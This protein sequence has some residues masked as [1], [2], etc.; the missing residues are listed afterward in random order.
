MRAIRLD[1][2]LGQLAGWALV[3]AVNAAMIAITLKLPRSGIGTRVLHH[4]YDAGQ[5]LALGA[6]SAVGVLFWQR[7]ASRTRFGSHRFAPSVAVFGVGV[8]FGVWMLRDDF[9]G[10]AGSLVGDR[11][12]F[13]V[14]ALAIAACAGLLSLCAR[15][16]SWLAR[17]YLRLLP[18]GIA[19]ALVAA[20]HK[21]V[22]HDYPGLHFFASAW[23]AVL[24]GTALVTSPA[25]ASFRSSGWVALGAVVSWW[26]LFL[27]PSN[28]VRLELFRSSGSVV[29]P[30]LAR[31]ESGLSRSSTAVVSPEAARWFKSRDG[32]PDIPPNGPPLFARNAIVLL[33]VI[34]A[35]RADLF[36][37][38][39]DQ[40][41]PNLARLRRQSV[42]FTNARTPAPGTTLAVTSV[43]TSRYHAQIRWADQR[44]R[45]YP[46]QDPSPRF[47][48]L[49][50]AHGVIT[51]NLQGLPGLAMSMGI[52]RG[53]DEEKIL[54]GRGG[55]YA[56][57][58]EMI[59]ALIQR[60]GRASTP[61]EA[62]RAFFAYQ[63]YDDAHAPYDLG[64]KKATPFESYLAEV[65]GVDREIG[66]LLD[67]LDS[68]SLADRTTLIVTADH[69]EAFGEHN[70]QFHATTLYDELLR[71]PLLVKIPSVAP[72][73][74]DVPVS[75][76]DLAPTLLDAFGLP[77][78]GRFMG[79]SLVPLLR[80]PRAPKLGRPIVAESDRGHRAMIFPDGMKV[81]VDDKLHTF[82]LYDL[83]RDPG[84]LQNLAD[85]AAD[86]G[87]QRRALLDTFFAAHRLRR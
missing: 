2:A 73:T 25:E 23:A 15:V 52:L 13:V 56:G 36:R 35:G 21:V 65:Q 8:L 50:R 33:L 72:R 76:V 44:G 80:D 1:P 84:E 53:F 28:A 14:V 24:A 31:I 75:L 37:P 43:L 20:N 70:K 17:G 85:S 10:F 16:G 11:W 63:H 71:V 39:H 66:R 51:L 22:S 5:L 12:S 58:P 45:E 55:H 41:L 79:Q 47:P 9:H 38:E 86:L 83:N 61:P 42:E 59:P 68:H 60:L 30:W 7:F 87:A 82:E 78:P 49:L 27:V 32:L 34:D 48:E 74:I 26:S 3:G 18:I 54:P 67:F 62:S 64:G 6:L 69:G 40:A 81:I 46:H 77:T 29:A 57:A 4:A 19:I